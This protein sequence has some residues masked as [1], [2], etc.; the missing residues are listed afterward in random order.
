MRKAT[1]E[2]DTIVIVSSAGSM[3]LVT[4]PSPLDIRNMW[5]DTLDSDYRSTGFQDWNVMGTTAFT[6]DGVTVWGA[7]LLIVG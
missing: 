7:I 4:W 2:M 5:M 3:E 6:S 1:H